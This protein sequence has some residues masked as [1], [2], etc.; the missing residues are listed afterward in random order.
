MIRMVTTVEVMSGH[1]DAWE[2]AWRMLRE[3]RRQYPGFHGAS[4][5]RDSSRPTHYLVLSEWESHDD[6]AEAMRELGWLN[7]ESTPSWTTGPLQVY[8]EVVDNLDDA[9]NAVH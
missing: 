1:E 9:T 2:E 7:R 5:L 6:L 4:L 3:T 8:D